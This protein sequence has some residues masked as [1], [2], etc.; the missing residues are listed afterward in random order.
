M[1]T[2][3]TIFITR[4]ITTLEERTNA[5]LLVLGL[6]EKYPNLELSIKHI[7]V[8]NGHEVI[9]RHLSLF[10]L[11]TPLTILAFT[12]QNGFVLVEI[13]INP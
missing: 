11:T 2:K 1:A 7:V 6:L 5:K 9:N 8:E 10:V 13:I 3:A 4:K 12:G